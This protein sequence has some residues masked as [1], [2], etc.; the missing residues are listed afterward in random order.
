M[1]ADL[2]EAR[3]A[4]F[5]EAVARANESAKRL[6]NG[7]VAAVAAL[8]AASAAFVYHTHAATS[9]RLDALHAAR[10]EPRST[11]TESDKPPQLQVAPSSLMDTPSSPPSG[12]LAA[13]P[14]APQVAADARGTGASGRLP[15]R[16]RAPATPACKSLGPHDP[17]CSPN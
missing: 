4:E 1:G 14:K 11:A 8:A 16:G 17:L 15:G 3:R 7:L 13:G 9:A 5:A 2:D 6:R 10:P 12:A